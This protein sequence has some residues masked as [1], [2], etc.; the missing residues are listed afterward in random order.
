MAPQGVIGHPPLSM[1]AVGA[2]SI[3]VLAWRGVVTVACLVAVAAPA[4]AGAVRWWTE[5]DV[6]AR[7]QLTAPQVAALNRLFDDTLSDRLASGARLTRLE[8]RLARLMAQPDAGEKETLRLVERVEGL[9]ARRNVARTMML[10]RMFRVLT[11]AQRRALDSLTR[12]K[13]VPPP[14]D[15]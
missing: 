15:P 10:V 13:P 14:R 2:T 4:A 12:P 8:Q 11:P 7:L 5:P 3:R 6:Q 1:D 9:R